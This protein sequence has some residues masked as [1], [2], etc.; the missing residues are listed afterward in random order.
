MNCRQRAASTDPVFT[1]TS[2]KRSFSVIQ[3]ERFGLVF[4]KNWVYN[5]G[6]CSV[7]CLTCSIK[8][9]PSRCPA[10][11]AQANILLLA[12]LPHLHNQILSCSLSCLTCSIKYSPARP[13]SPAQSN[14]F[15][16][17]A[18]PHLPNQILSCA[19]IYR[20]SFH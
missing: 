7:S 10:S 20:P 6:H 9:S 14:T 13:A 11:S 12:A 1:K 4:C 19:R 8:Y 16:L 3:N 2:P 18:L 17:A 5:F 15:L